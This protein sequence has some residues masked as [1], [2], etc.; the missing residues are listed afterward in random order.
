MR[1]T[2]VIIQTATKVILFIILIFSLYLFFAGH[3]QPGGGFVGGLVSAAAIVLL[4]MAFG[5]GILRQGLPLD[6][7]LLGATGGFIV[8]ASGLGS[9]L[10][11]VP[12]L[13]QTYGVM[14]LP[15]FGEVEWS[16][17]VLFDLGVFL[18][19]IGVTLTII[20]SISEDG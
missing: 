7:K 14:R 8:V 3:H 1:F 2:N 5:L 13:S 19:V 4:A 15:L 16:T 9:L 20:L 6:F 18:A 10:V 11:D 12:F 17:A